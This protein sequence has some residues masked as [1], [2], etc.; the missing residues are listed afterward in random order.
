MGRPKKPPVKC[1]TPGCGKPSRT[2]GLC[3]SC[4]R[5]ARRRVLRKEITD[6]QLV[7]LGVMKPA[8][9]RGPESVFGKHLDKVLAAGK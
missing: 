5:T 1:L 9:K 8:Q 7:K 4:F 6:A 2:R 3:G